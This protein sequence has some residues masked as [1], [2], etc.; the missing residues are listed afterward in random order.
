MKTDPGERKEMKGHTSKFSA[1]SEFRVA[2]IPAEKTFL[3][4]TIVYRASANLNCS[5]QTPWLW[6]SRP[7]RIESDAISNACI[8]LA[9]SWLNECVSSH[10][11]CG[12]P[13]FLTGNWL[14]T[15]L[16]DVGDGATAPRLV[17]SSTIDRDLSGHQYV[18]LSHCWDKEQ[19]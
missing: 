16:I 1:R 10:A 19:P 3:L 15:R 18:A 8:Q 14:T 6:I 17:D 9:R 12:H 2:P 11:Q 5:P 4:A 7:R 13:T